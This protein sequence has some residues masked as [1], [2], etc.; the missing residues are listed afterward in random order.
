MSHETADHEYGLYKKMFLTAGRDDACV[1][2]V[3]H[4]P[5]TTTSALVRY[6]QYIYS[7]L[8]STGELSKCLPRTVN[9]CEVPMREHI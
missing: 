8:F 1:F 4:V 7:A 6:S 5:F 9:L 2:Y 3:S